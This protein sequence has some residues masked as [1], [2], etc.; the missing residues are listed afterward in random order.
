MAHP[1]AAQPAVA[2]KPAPTPHQSAAHP[3]HAAPS[4][5]AAFREALVSPGTSKAVHDS[6][7]RLKAAVADDTA[8]KVEAVL[9][10]MLRE[11][12]D[13]NLP[14]LVEKMVRE[15]IERISRR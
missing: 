12:L 1:A 11:W 13:N 15:E 8:A 10:P 7:D 2:E 3:A 4:E 5:L 6:F 14:G 9:R